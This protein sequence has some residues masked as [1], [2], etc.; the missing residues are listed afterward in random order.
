MLWSILDHASKGKVSDT[1]PLFKFP[2]C[3]PHEVLCINFDFL[4]YCIKLIFICIPWFGSTSLNLLPKEVPHSPR[5]SPRP[6]ILLSSKDQVS[7][8]KHRSWVLSWDSNWCS[9]RGN[10]PISLPLH[11]DAKLAS[12]IPLSKGT[13]E[14]RVKSLALS[15]KRG[16]EMQSRF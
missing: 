1:N 14:Q 4:N 6:G 7:V 11:S 5:P 16:F 13:S 12:Q 3:V 8:R 15:C 10:F 2:Y 9:P